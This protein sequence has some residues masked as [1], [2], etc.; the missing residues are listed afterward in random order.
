[1]TA[2]PGCSWHAPSTGGVPTEGKVP[3]GRLFTA[4]T[5]SCER[6]SFIWDL[7]APAA[8]PSPTDQRDGWT[9]SRHLTVL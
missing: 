6:F 5:F 9:G 2:S 4:V 1:M 3:L 7:R 8:K